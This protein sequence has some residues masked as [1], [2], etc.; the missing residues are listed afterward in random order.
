[1]N[2]RQVF[3]NINIYENVAHSLTFP[4]LTF[5]FTIEL[6]LI[7]FNKSPNLSQ[8]TYISFGTN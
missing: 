7:F 2:S 3:R 1:M 8:V 4:T 5:V 6:I